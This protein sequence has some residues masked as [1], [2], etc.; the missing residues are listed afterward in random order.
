MQ[1]VVTGFNILLINSVIVKAYTGALYEDPNNCA[2][3]DQYRRGWSCPDISVSQCCFKSDELF[4]SAEVVDEGTSPDKLYYGGTAFSKQGDNSCA[5]Y[6][7]TDRPVYEIRIRSFYL[8][9]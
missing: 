1:T 8:G 5:V 6:V 4:G 7:S 2:Q 9:Y 3:S